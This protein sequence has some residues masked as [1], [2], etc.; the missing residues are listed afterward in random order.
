MQDTQAGFI[1]YFNGRGEVMASMPDFY[2]AG[3][4][5]DYEFIYKNLRRKFN[6]GFAGIISSTRIQY[7]KNSLEAFITHYF[8]S[9][10]VSPNKIRVSVPDYSNSGSCR[11]VFDGEYPPIIH[12]NPEYPTLKDVLK[13]KKGL[14]YFQAL[15][16]TDDDAETIYA[17]LERLTAGGA[18]HTIHVS[19]LCTSDRRSKYESLD[20]AA[21]FKNN[22]CISYCFYAD[23]L[24]YHVCSHAS[25]ALAPFAG[26]ARK[27]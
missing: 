4:H 9:T 16:N 8:G 18:E 3:K 21:G 22:D 15:C 14:R 2:E 19:T 13:T 27:K 26:L 5:E 7:E 25:K 11:W 6:S 1:D 17:S 20:R 23:L 10:V 12:D 24:H